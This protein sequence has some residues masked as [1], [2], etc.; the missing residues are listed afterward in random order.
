MKSK[1]VVLL[2]SL[3]LLSALA[4]AAEATVLRIIVV[5]TDNLDGY[6][7]EVE[8]GR[9]IFKRLQSSATVRAWRA[10]FAGPEA[11]G[12]VVSVE[13]PDLATLAKDEAKGAADPE[14]QAWL[15]GLDKLRKIVSDSLY[16]ELP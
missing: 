14:Y 5:Q 12:V 2:I 9:A 7:K 1:A 6:L 8:R 11:G 16:Q 3:V 13:Y 10:K 15:K 4:S